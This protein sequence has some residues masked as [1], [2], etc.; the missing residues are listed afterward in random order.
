MIG[1]YFVKEIEAAHDS[2][3]NQVFAF[4]FPANTSLPLAVFI[5]ITEER[6]HSHSGVSNL[7]LGQ[8]QIS[9]YAKTLY[10]VNFLAQEIISQFDSWT[11]PADYNDNV[12]VSYVHTQRIPITNFDDGTKAYVARLAVN[13]NWHEL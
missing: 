9:I 2:F 12:H 10:D 6:P 3:D 13:A 7:V 1:E 11:T 4:V 5:P 8:Y